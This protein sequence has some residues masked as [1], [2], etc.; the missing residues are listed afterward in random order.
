MAKLTRVG[1]AES[2]KARQN[3]GTDDNLSKLVELNG[4]YRIFARMFDT[5]AGRLDDA[6]MPMEPN[7]DLL[8]IAR[9]GRTAD[10]DICGTSF[11]VYDDTMAELDDETGKPVDLVGLD[12]W[13]RI[14]TVLHA[15]QA[16]RE[17]KN[18]EAEA[19]RTARDLGEDI[20]SAAL[21]QKL[22]AIDL[23]Y[24]GGKIGDKT[25]M[26]EVQPPLSKFVWKTLTQIALVPMATQNG[27]LT[28][29][30]KNARYA[31]LEISSTRDNQ[32]RAAV[33]NRDYYTPGSEFIELAYAYTGA[34]KNEA[35]RSA[36][37]TG[38]A[39]SLRLS[40]VFPDSWKSDGK[41]FV[42]GIA[43]GST[44]EDTANLMAN[45]S[46][47][48]SRKTDPQSV[49]TSMRKYFATNKALAVS[50]DFE[51]DSTKYAAIDL[52][53]SG[54]LDIVP[55][56]KEKIAAIADEQRKNRGKSEPEMTEEEVAE[57]ESNARA[58][59]AMGQADAT[60][61]LQSIMNG[62]GEGEDLLA[63]D[64]L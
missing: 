5:N 38:V 22:D 7:W 62:I 39:E 21:K 51:A 59:Q 17:K 37:L 63:S 13:K 29:Q 34:N 19:E 16:S 54:L 43:K 15:A 42:E 31:I 61:S 47:A 20:D 46:K 23:K 11:I 9:L 27:Q 58:I 25:I 55:N 24:F 8:S 44:P 45:R 48:L 32:I 30:W 4:N 33:N 49:I 6:G 56:V 60:Q 3:L 50:I 10:Y 14:G 52:I 40:K 26:A 2:K 1:L 53:D 12:P 28:P 57:E 36:A 18:A 35:G 64:D 41:S